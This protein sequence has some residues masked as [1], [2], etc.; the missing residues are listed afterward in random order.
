[1]TGYATGTGNRLS[2]DGTYTYTYDNEGN[3]LTKT[4]TSD[5]QTTTFTW[6]YRNRLTEVVIKTAGGTTVQD[7]KFTYDV[8]NRRIGK[9]TFGGTQ[10]W[11]IYNGANPYA[12]FNGATLA[13]RY[14]YGNALDFL[15]ARFD[16][17]TTMWYLTDKLGSVRQDVSTNG[18]VLDQLVY[19]SY[20]NILSETNAGNGDRFKFT[21]REWD[22]ELGLYFY[23][24]RYY[25]PAD[26][27]FES[28]DPQGFK[29]GDPDLY[30][31]VNNSPISHGDPTGLDKDP[32]SSGTGLLPSTPPLLPFQRTPPTPQE[33]LFNRKIAL[34]EEFTPDEMK[35]LTPAQRAEV[36]KRRRE[37]GQVLLQ[38]INDIVIKVPSVGDRPVFNPE[39]LGKT[40]PPAFNEFYNGSLRFGLGNMSL[41]YTQSKP[42]GDQHYIN[43]GLFPS[44]GAGKGGKGLTDPHIGNFGP[45]LNYIYAPGQPGIIPPKVDPADPLFKINEKRPPP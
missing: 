6:D 29:A 8:E 15:L 42:G 16:G 38:K 27:R 44:T 4:R 9:L 18:T 43:F 34:G 33:E 12:D 32:G 20:G 3:T 26:G 7:D 19:D 39:D 30:R 10:L 28:E 5:G 14:L 17:T 40:V 37:R 45:F 36:Y 31:Y 23:R 11:T 2:N 24:R 35:S 25:G 1:M 21:G 41:I 22:A 13:Y